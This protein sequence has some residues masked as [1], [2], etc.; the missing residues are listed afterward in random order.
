MPKRLLNQYRLERQI[1]RFQRNFFVRGRKSADT[2]HVRWAS[3]EHLSEVGEKLYP[4]ELFAKLSTDLWAK[5]SERHQ[6]IVSGGGR[7]MQTEPS[8]RTASND[9]DR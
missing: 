2:D 8:A 5:I 3:P 1:Q 9:A 4:G 7:S 6:F